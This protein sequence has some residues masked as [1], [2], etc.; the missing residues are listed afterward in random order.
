MHKHMLEEIK[1]RK[2]EKDI[3]CLSD[4]LGMMLDVAK[5]ENPEFYE[6]IECKLYET[7][8]GKVLTHEKAEKIIVHMKP[9]GMHWSEDQIRQVLKEKNIDLPIVD[10]WIVMNMAYNDYHGLFDE[11]LEMYVKF[12]KMFIRDADAKESKVY[13]YFTEIPQ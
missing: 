8:Y 10:A 6:H 13:T 4:L 5:E 3:E 9:Y 7:L 2:S 11:N 1:K 12:T